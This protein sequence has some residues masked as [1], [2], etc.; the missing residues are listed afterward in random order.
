MENDG[1]I[2]WGVR[3]HGWREQEG[4]PEIVERVHE[5][6]ELNEEDG[7]GVSQSIESQEAEGRLSTDQEE[8]ELEEEPPQDKRRRISYEEKDEREHRRRKVKRRERREEKRQERKQQ[9]RKRFDGGDGTSINDLVRTLPELEDLAHEKMQ[10]EWPMWRDMVVSALDLRNPAGRKWTESEKHLALMLKGGRHV[11]EIAALAA[12]VAGEIV[13]DEANEEPKFSNLIKRINA[14]FRPRD[15]TTEITVLRNMLQKRE[16]SVREYIDRARRQV[17][18]CGYRTT[19]ERDRELVMLLKQNATDAIQISQHSMGQSLEQMEALA[20]NLEAIRMRQQRSVET[21]AQEP[22]VDVHAVMEKLGGWGQRNIAANSQRV[23]SKPNRN[24][25]DCA[26]CGRR[27]GH[28]PGWKCR[29]QSME[30]FKCGRR[31]HTAA[32]CEQGSGSGRGSRGGNQN[33]NFRN[34]QQNGSGLQQ[35]RGNQSGPR[36]VSINKVSASGSNKT[37]NGWT[38]E[39]ENEI[40]GELMGQ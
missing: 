14:T 13:I 7:S 2:G 37:S 17:S 24:V 21:R 5:W 35:D 22:D 38:P 28:E 11:R 8:S 29:A 40:W 33:G 30:C 39:E 20:I 25:A 27:G 36:A 15:P 6:L 26:F 34:N 10:L 23:G 4:P 32:V 16:E 1:N 31:G 3:P 19:E 18:L 12:P 9:R